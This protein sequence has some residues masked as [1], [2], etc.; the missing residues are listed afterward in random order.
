MPTR[1]RYLVEQ[2]LRHHWSVD[3]GHR[4]R[5][6]HA[7]NSTRSRHADDL[8]PQIHQVSPLRCQA[9]HSTMSPQIHRASQ[10][11]TLRAGSAARSPL[12]R[13]TSL[14]EGPPAN[15]SEGRR[16]KTRS[17]VGCIHA[18]LS[19]LMDPLHRRRP[20]TV[21]SIHPSSHAR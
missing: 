19:V 16:C 17:P 5:V 15:P 11:K 1:C 10:S 18:T 3:L 21:M 7:V 4:I 20:L 9:A 6:L 8:C 13:R 12:L 14:L 2:D